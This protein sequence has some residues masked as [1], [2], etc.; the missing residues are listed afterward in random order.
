MDQE[1]RFRLKA[2]LSFFAMMLLGM[3]LFT[4]LLRRPSS[5]LIPLAEPTLAVESMTG[6]DSQS[7]CTATVTT[8]MLNQRSGP[9]ETYTI[10]GSASNGERFTVKGR[11]T[12]E[13]WIL[14]DT[15]YGTAW[16]AARYTQL[17]GDCDTLSTTTENGSDVEVAMVFATATP[18]TANRVVSAASSGSVA[19][20]SLS[21]V[22]TPEVQFWASEI[23]AWAAAYNIDVNVI[24]T[25]I[26][27]ESC[28]NPTVNS[29]AGAQGLFQVMPF[30]F[31]AGEDMLDVETNAKRGLAYLQGAL[32]LSQGDVGLALVGY[33]GGYGAITGRRYAET[34]R[35]YYWGSGIYEDAIAGELTS[36]VLQ[37]WLAA[38]GSNLCA[39]ASRTQQTLQSD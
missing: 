20:T 19:S 11:D 26:Q 14:V 7:S 21:P 28:G 34:Q 23:A 38:G 5:T 3:H 32:R 22:F 18:A 6:A 25:V 9:G 10:M 2:V 33:N 29:S 8:Q 24:A 15:P 17:S 16:M 12:S 1:N 36:D 31:E 37:E 27:I 4:L 30:H 39:R 13:R 35:Y